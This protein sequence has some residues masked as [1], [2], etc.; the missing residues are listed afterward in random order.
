MEESIRYMKSNTAMLHFY[1]KAKDVKMVIKHH[2]NKLGNF[3]NGVDF[4]H[5]SSIDG[6]F[7]KI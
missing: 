5:C 1:I 6:N 2:V 3:S 4:F 7:L